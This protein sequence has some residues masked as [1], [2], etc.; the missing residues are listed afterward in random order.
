MTQLY[1]FNQNNKISSKCELKKSAY[2][3]LISIHTYV[4][5]NQQ[6]IVIIL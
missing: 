4:Y 6:Y 1:K 3:S 5:Q 2:N